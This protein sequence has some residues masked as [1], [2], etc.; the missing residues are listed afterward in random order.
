MFWNVLT[1]KIVIDII[2]TIIEVVGSLALLTI[3]LFIIFLL[4]LT[5]KSI[6]AYEY[7]LVEEEE[8]V[9][10]RI[11]TIKFINITPIKS[12]LIHLIARNMNKEIQ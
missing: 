1:I 6:R 4:F 12:E 11:E 10:A 9:M 8:K 5:S 7:Q 2:V 3:L